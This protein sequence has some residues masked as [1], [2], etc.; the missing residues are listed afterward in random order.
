MLGIGNVGRG[1]FD[2]GDQ[3]FVKEE[4]SSK[5]WVRS[6]GQEIGLADVVIVVGFERAVVEEGI[7]TV[8]YHMDLVSS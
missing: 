2:D 6:G 3:V 1:S 8:G 4:L 5:Q 7:V